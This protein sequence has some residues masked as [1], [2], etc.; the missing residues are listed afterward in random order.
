M[1]NTQKNE[2]Y[3]KTRVPCQVIAFVDSEKNR[4]LF[5]ANLEK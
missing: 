2:R 1:P 3:M 4:I 5:F